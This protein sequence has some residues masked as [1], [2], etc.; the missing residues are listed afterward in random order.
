[1]VERHSAEIEIDSMQGR[2][3]TVRLVFS[4]PITMAV[5][6]P[7][8]MPNVI[9]PSMRLL[10]VDDDPMLLKS[11]RDV[12][13]LDG[14]AVTTASGGQAGIEAFRMAQETGEAFAMVITDLGMPHIDGR[15]VAEAVKKM[16]PATPVILLTGWGRRLMSSGDAPP[17]VDCILSKPPKLRELRETFVRLSPPHPTTSFLVA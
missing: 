14:H 16:S 3:T 1:M 11:L 13:E 12:L 9:V 4:V 10:I 8:E 2:G 15:R 5:L 7:P 6:V 17:H